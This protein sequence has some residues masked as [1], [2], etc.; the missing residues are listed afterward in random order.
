MRN[1]CICVSANQSLTHCKGYVSIAGEKLKKLQFASMPDVTG[2]LACNPNNVEVEE[3]STTKESIMG[4]MPVGGFTPSKGDGN[5]DSMIAVVGSGKK[6]AFVLGKDDD[7]GNVEDEGYV[8]DDS[9]V[10]Q[11]FGWSQDANFIDDATM[12]M[13]MLAVQTPENNEAEAEFNARSPAK[14][15]KRKN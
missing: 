15:W 5:E 13:L 10:E 6:L 7:K 14:F 3:T 1:A 2:A 4:P 11:D 8:S 12:E 9:H